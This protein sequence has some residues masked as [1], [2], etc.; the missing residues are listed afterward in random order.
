M[1]NCLPIFLD[2]LKNEITRLTAV[3]ALIKIANSDLKIDLKPILAESLPILAGFLRKNQR[4]LK[5][6]SLALLDI[7][8]R[9]YSTMIT[10]KS[11]ETVLVELQPLLNDSDLHIA[12]LTMNLLT[13]V[14]KLHKS[15]LPTV[16]RTSLS[17]IFLL[18]QSP[19]L[20]GAALNAMLDFFKALVA[21]KLPGLGQ[22]ELLG[23]LVDPVLAPTGA[24]IHKQGRA[25][26]AKCVAALVVTQSAS[27]AQNVV[28]HF[29]ANLKP[30]D[31]STAHQQ[32]FSLLVIGEIGK[33]T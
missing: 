21:A 2:R 18:A 29:A 20:Q 32:T 1:P 28:S 24:A 4:A 11:L 31:P 10:D 26:I 7:L 33:H 15:S 30:S 8:V 17:Y 9:N 19:L 27:E 3:K 16:Q 13:S 22:K 25:S 14:A 5:L 6:S 23:L 12:Q